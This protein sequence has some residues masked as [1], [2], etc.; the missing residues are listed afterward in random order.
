MPELAFRTVVGEDEQAL[1]DAESGDPEAFGLIVRRHQAMVFSLALRFLHDRPA[2]E[3]LAQEVFLELYRNLPAMRSAIHM[4][5]WLRRVTSHRCIDRIRSESV[6]RTA[7]L[8][9]VPEPLTSPPAGDLLLGERLRVLV[10]QLPASARMVVL[11]RYQE[12]L[13]PSEI[14]AV[15]DMPVNTVKSHLRR[16]LSTLR[17][18]LATLRQQLP[19]E[20]V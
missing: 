4:R 12:D 14:A 16:S 15:L 2:A 5:F 3:D 7:P 1:L 8:D 6:R 10:G 20:G 13:D 17:Q 18:Q 19:S 9:G 11:L